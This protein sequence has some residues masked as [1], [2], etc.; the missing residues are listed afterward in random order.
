ML[1]S[2]LPIKTT[3]EGVSL[4]EGG[5]DY[6]HTFCPGL[7]NGLGYRKLGQLIGSKATFTV[8]VL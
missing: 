8:A 7:Q 5:T 2:E 3:R 1:G 4:R 6:S